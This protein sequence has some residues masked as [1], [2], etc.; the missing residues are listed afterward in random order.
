MSSEQYSFGSDFNPR[1]LAI[2]RHPDVSSMTILFMHFCFQLRRSRDVIAMILLHSNSLS[3][4]FLSKVVLHSVLRVPYH[5]IRLSYS[6]EFEG[7]SISFGASSSVL[8]SHVTIPTSLIIE[9]IHRS[10][11]NGSINLSFRR[12]LQA[13]ISSVLSTMLQFH[14]VFLRIAAWSIERCKGSSIS[15]PITSSNS[16]S[17]PIASS[18]RISVRIASSNSASQRWASI[19]ITDLILSPLL[20]QLSQCI[21]KVGPHHGSY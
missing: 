14:C 19:L 3:I 1:H 21:C 8:G 6:A 20:E 5:S 2:P 16:I 4:A 13:T 11:I 7:S 17:V 15:A 10:L 18:N 9:T 12:E